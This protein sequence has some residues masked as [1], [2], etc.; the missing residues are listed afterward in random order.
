MSIYIA[1]ALAYIASLTR[2]CILDKISSILSMGSFL[3][4]QSFKSSDEGKILDFDSIPDT[5]TKNDKHEFSF[6]GE[7]RYL[8]RL[9][10]FENEEQLSP[11]R[12][13]QP[14]GTSC[15]L[16]WFL[17]VERSTTCFFTSKI[18]SPY[19]YFSRSKLIFT[20]KFNQLKQGLSP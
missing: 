6:S 20:H 5:L 17:Y 19:F 4:L 12:S 11:S 14:S 18:K 10:V 15:F 2:L 13:A 1:L 8:T 7:T 16:L 3:N 9:C